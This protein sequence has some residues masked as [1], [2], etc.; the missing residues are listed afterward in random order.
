VESPHK[1]SILPTVDYAATPHREGREFCEDAVVVGH[2]D[3]ALAGIALLAVFEGG[4]P[5]RVAILAPRGVDVFSRLRPR[6]CGAHAPARAHDDLAAAGTA[7]AERH[8]GRAFRRRSP[9]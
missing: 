9:G 7:F 2:S 4:N 6:Q 3:D 1:A 5:G 8:F